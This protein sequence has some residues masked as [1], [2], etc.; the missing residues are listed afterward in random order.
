M[1]PRFEKFLSHDN[2]KAIK[3]GGFGYLNGINYM[4]PH[5]AGGVGNLCSHASKG[6]I[7]LCLGEHSGQAAISSKVK[8]S[9]IYKARYF[10]KERGAFMS[11][12]ALHCAKLYRKAQ[13]AGLKTAIRP[14]GSTDIAFEGVAFEIPESV[15][16]K[17]SGILGREFPAQKYRNIFE[18]FPEIQ[19]L[20]YTKNARRFDRTLPP[21][22]HLTFS[23]SETNHETARIL[24]SRSVSCAVVFGVLPHPES[25][26]HSKVINGDEHDLRFLDPAGVIVG[27]TPKGH[28]AKRDTSG[29]VVRL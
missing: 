29:F 22:Y 4:A 25:F 15:A 14:N 16:K 24:L 13:A 2:P 26:L 11:E 23:V 21:N 10:M 8:Q 9:R 28:K 19:F 18:A 6:C 20:D 1:K 12:F 3:A 7:S 17:I 5:K 27:L